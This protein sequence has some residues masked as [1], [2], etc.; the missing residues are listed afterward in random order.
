MWLL[1]I[2]CGGKKSERLLMEYGKGRNLE[3]DCR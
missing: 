2:I 1:M 3:R